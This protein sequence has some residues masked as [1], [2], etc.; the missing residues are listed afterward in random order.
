[1][2]SPPT[3]SSPGSCKKPVNIVHSAILVA[4][5][6]EDEFGGD[7]EGERPA[8]KEREGDMRNVPVGAQ[9]NRPRL[10]PSI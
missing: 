7:G 6:G 3:R 1:M 4:G 10:L 8:E 9:I 5:D 2:P